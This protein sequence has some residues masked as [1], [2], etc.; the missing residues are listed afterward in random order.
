[1]HELVLLKKACLLV[2]FV[3]RWGRTSL[4]GKKPAV[5]QVLVGKTTPFVGVKPIFG[6][7]SGEGG[8]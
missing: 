3:G 7:F 1:M 5:G 2:G 6:I 8:G 4:K